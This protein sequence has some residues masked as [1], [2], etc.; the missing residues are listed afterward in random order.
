MGLANHT[1]L[2]GRD[3]TKR[4]IDDSAAPIRDEAG[5]VV[6]V[7]LVFRD[8]TERK[9]AEE[10]QARLAA[11]VESSQDAI[12]SKTLD[13]IIRSWNSGAERL[14]GYTAQEAIGRSITLIIPPERHEKRIHRG[15]TAEWVEPGDRADIEAGPLIDISLT[16]HLS[17]TAPTC[18]SVSKVA[19]ILRGNGP[20][21]LRAD[22]VTS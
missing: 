8:I 7:V 16:I 22:R 4:P 10:T 14:F 9:R 18:C 1:V 11:I 17:G 21:R 3:G 5:E 15:S 13:G 12:I 6:G 2:V 20:K 19:L